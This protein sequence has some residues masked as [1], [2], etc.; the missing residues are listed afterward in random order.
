M[1]FQ[2]ITI[3]Q[4]LVVAE[5]NIVIDVRSPSEYKHAHIPSAISLPL[6]SDEER[7][8]IGTAYKQESKEIAI[9]HGL[10]FFG[11]KMHGIVEKV[12]ELLLSSLTS[13][14]ESSKIVLLYC[15]RGGMRSNA[16]AWLL[17]FYGFE[18]FLLEGGYKNFRNWGIQQFEKAYNFN[19]IGGFTGSGKTMILNEFQNN[20]EIQIDLEGLA[21]HKGSTLG[22]IG[23]DPQPSQEMFE[24][25]LAK[26]LYASNR[27]DINQT[28][29]IEDESQRIGNLF[30]PLK[31][32][33]K[34]R[35]SKIWFLSI[36]FEVRLN[37]LVEEYGKH[38]P[39]LLIAAIERI[40]KRLGGLETKN[41][42]E[43]LLANDSKECFRI[44]LRYYDR[45]YEKGL[46]AREN[47]S[48]LILTIEANSIDPIFNRT[49]I[50]K[51]IKLSE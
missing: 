8:I 34:M 42:I 5:S 13:T 38:S 18:V 47:L 44:L 6:F 3:E 17:D 29:F 23:Q 48:D 46:N 39:V 9:K 22:A 28:I 50:L 19:V 15:W 10:D 1:A 11:P 51:N 12:E 43:Y 32:Y 14:K 33:E 35:R 40:Q 7:K 25:L 27:G 36:P 16:M 49:L 37:Y 26:E 31:V 20:N 4:F 21:N 24:N 41:A 45:W 30:I 2:K